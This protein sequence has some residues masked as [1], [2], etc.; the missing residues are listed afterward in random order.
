MAEE[1][2]KDEKSEGSGKKP[3]EGSKDKTGDQ[4]GAQSLKP[5]ETKPGE[6]G[7]QPPKPGP[8]AAAR[9]PEKKT[10]PSVP[11]AGTGAKPASSTP[12]SATGAK[13]AEAKRPPAAP[14][15][16]ARKCGCLSAG[17]WL[18]A[19]LV[20]IVVGGY[21]TWPY[22]SRYAEPYLP[23]MMTADGSRVAALESRVAEIEQK[24]KA[25]RPEIEA[26]RALQAGRQKVNEQLGS[27]LNQVES[28]QKAITSLSRM[29]ELVKGAESGDAEKVVAALT[30]KIDEVRQDLARAE[31]R[32]DR[33]AADLAKRIDEVEA[34]AQSED[35]GVSEAVAAAL[36]AGQLA[37]ALKGSGPFSA[38]LDAV[39]RALLDRLG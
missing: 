28:L 20:V 11:P 22:W 10:G 23:K 34:E 30:L 14:P 21:F 2:K 4:P 7:G 38:E 29:A 36:T 26:I 32:A 37:Q 15:K 12:P 27:A 6:T 19:V 13:P 16:K 8:A 31:E 25:P 3:N 33:S 5:T 9:E 35:K 39:K 17:L 24:L 1:S 18:V